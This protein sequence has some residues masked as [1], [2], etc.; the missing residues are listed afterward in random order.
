MGKIDFGEIYQQISNDIQMNREE[1]WK[2]YRCAAAVSKGGII[3]EIGTY[4][5]GSAMIMAAAT[6]AIVYTIDIVSAQIIEKV[7]EFLNINP[8]CGYSK[9]IA[10][11]WDKGEIDMLFIDGDHI[12]DLVM[13]D[14]KGWIPK[15]KD[16]GIICFHD[17]GSRPE[18][19]HA[20]TDALE[21]RKGLPNHSLLTI[22]K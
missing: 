16:G 17:Y 7:K 6:E 18:V 5:G 14:I 13:E 2:L 10:A 22:I 20:I 3:V 8:I 9:D 21:Q 19:T 4:K 11:G 15:V 12:Y 1:A